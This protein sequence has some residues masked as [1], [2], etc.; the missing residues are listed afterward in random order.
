M[1][2]S[3][4]LLQ[5]VEDK[6]KR[7]PMLSPLSLWRGL[8]YEKRG[9]TYKAIE[10]YERAAL[11]DESDRQPYVCAQRIFKTLGNETAVTVIQQKLDEKFSLLD[12]PSGV[13][14]HS[15][16]KLDAVV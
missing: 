16:G 14:W 6:M 5:V 13:V 10:M 9:K 8:L 7:F 15:K 1:S 12:I 11:L 4:L 3:A 2:N